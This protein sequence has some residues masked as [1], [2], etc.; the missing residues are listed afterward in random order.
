MYPFLSCSFT[1]SLISS[2]SCLDIKY[3][4]DKILFQINHIVPWFGILSDSSFLNTFSHL[5]NFCS[6]IS[7]TFS[8]SSSI[9]SSNFSS[10]VHSYFFLS[11]FSTFLIL[12]LI[13]FLCSIS[14]F[15][16]KFLSYKGGHL[17]IFT[18]LIS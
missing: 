11:A 17:V 9:S 2:F 12:F 15:T 14:F 16:A 18:S 10:I 1:N 4:W 5:W 8:L 6:T 3:I 7:F 13:F